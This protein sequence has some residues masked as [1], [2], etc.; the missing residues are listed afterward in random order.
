MPSNTAQT[1]GQ[2]AT[3]AHTTQGTQT[4]GQPVTGNVSGVSP[5]IAPPTGTDTYSGVQLSGSSIEGGSK[6]QQVVGNQV[7]NPSL[8]GGTRVKSQFIQ[9]TPSQELDSSQFQINEREGLINRSNVELDNVTDVVDPN[10]VAAGTQGESVKYDAA[11]VDPNSAEGKTAELDTMQ[12]QLDELLD[13]APGAF[14]PWM[15]GAAR[16]ALQ[17]MQERGVSSSTM[18]GEALA[19]AIAQ[20]ALPVAQHDAQVFERMNLT[21]IANRAQ[22]LLSNQ[23]ADNAARQTNSQN[24][25]QHKQFVENLRTGVKAQNANQVNSMKKFNTQSQ[26]AVEQFDQ[27]MKTS[28]QKFNMQNKIAI[29]QANVAWRRS[30]NM[31]NTAAVNADNQQNAQNMLSLSNW[32]M[33]A[34]WQEYRDNA[35]WAF[36]SGENDKIRAHNLTLAALNREAIFDQIDQEGKDKLFQVIGSFA[37]NLLGKIKFQ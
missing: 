11:F 14:P 5:V 34:V 37:T 3:T 7:N 25:Q 19:A 16:S 2:V 17:K 36:Q 10:Q 1:T 26:L 22:F 6:I 24:E 28:R 9:N 12:G 4:S 18:M 35:S 27:Q 23:A 29:D 21:N 30:I 31:A 20:A 33:S 8:P 15:K 32:G 13:F